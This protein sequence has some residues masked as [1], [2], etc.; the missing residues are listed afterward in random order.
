[1]TREE[2]QILDELEEARHRV[3]I[4]EERQSVLAKVRL[5]NEAR[6]AR[7]C[8]IAGAFG[9][10]LETI[11][12]LGGC[13]SV[14]AESF[15]VDVYEKDLTVSLRRT[16]TPSNNPEYATNKP[17]VVEALQALARQLK[18]SQQAEWDARTAQL[19]LVKQLL[20]KAQTAGV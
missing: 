9:L 11:S 10:A 3:Q 4:L 14:C 15:R 16:T 1:M 6:N 8:R 13:L 17:S 5:A 12:D 18:T 20:T 19:D 2:K 7:A